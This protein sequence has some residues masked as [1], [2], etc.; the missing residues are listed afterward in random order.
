MAKDTKPSSVRHNCIHDRALQFPLEFLFLLFLL[1][2]LHDSIPPPL[3]P[4]HPVVRG[5]ADVVGLVQL[6]VVGEHSILLRPNAVVPG[7]AQP[8]LDQAARDGGAGLGRFGEVD[9][10]Q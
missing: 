3:L 9:F 6:K 7:M 10:L 4:G 1:F 2:Q 8:G 5:E